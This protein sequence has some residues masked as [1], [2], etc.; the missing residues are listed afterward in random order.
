M[1]SEVL[2]VN[3]ADLGVGAIVGGVITGVVAD[4]ASAG[5]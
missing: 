2:A 5:C 3:L 4:R 1:D